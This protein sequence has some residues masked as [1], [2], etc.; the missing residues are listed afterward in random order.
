MDGWR[1]GWRES[2]MDDVRRQ[3]KQGNY[4]NIV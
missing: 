2:W 1:D 4:N 3:S